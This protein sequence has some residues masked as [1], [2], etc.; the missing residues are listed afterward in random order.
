MEV[1]STSVINADEIDDDEWGPIKEK[2]SKKDKSK[3]APVTD[4]RASS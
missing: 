2:K 4:D 3:P 1:K